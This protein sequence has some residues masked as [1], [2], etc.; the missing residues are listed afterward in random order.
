MSGSQLNV[1]T[2]LGLSVYNSTSLNS[3]HI[4]YNNSYVVL[5]ICT[6]I[7]FLERVVDLLELPESPA[8]LPMLLHAMPGALDLS[9]RLK[10]K[11]VSDPFLDETGDVYSCDRIMK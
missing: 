8:H 5:V 2:P 6:S 3:S 10:P 7:S 11:L 1:S 4:L 9:C